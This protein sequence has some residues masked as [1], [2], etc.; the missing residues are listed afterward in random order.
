MHEFAYAKLN[1]ALHVRGRE[2]DGYHRIETAFAFAQ[3]GDMLSVVE[4]EGISLGVTGPFADSLAGEDNI[5]L[6]AA[7]ALRERCGIGAGAAL[8][9]DKRLPVASGIGG[10]SADAAAALRLLRR[11]WRADLPEAAL[12]E[13][14][15]GLGADV[16]ACFHSRTARGEGRGD[17]LEFTDYGLGGA[18]LL[19]V[20][21]GVRLSTRDVFERWDGRDRGPLGDPRIG[22]NDLEAPAKGLVPEIG[23]VLEALAALDTATMIRMSGSGA[24]CFALFTEEADRDRASRRFAHRH[25]HWWRLASRLR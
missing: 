9:L 22:R 16:L 13:L 6:K 11:W 21:P 20:N 25:P 12:A 3:D 5:V 1:L 19:L 10:G 7:N 4:G 18:P 14:A 2:P 8:T 17:R 23:E 24:T 15:R